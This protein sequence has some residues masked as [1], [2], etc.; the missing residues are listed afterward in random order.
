MEKQEIVKQLDRS[1]QEVIVFVRSL[2]PEQQ[3]KSYEQKWSVGQHL[4]HLLRSVQPLNKA[5]RVPLPGL[6]ILFG[7]PNREERSYEEV[8]HKY[9]GLIQNGAKASGRYIPTS[10]QQL[11]GIEKKYIEQSNK[12]VKN[13]LKWD[14]KDMSS[15]LLP[16]PLLGK[17]TVKEMLYFTLFHT[18][19]HLELMKKATFN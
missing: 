10:S 11:T 17:L 5:L 14:E 6:R 18:R 3:N 9:N 12:L 7:S 13:I 1:S 15:Y 8:L 4:D 16:H 2:N 19:H